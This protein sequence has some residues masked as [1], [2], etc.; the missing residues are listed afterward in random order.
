M[1]ATFSYK[2]TIRDEKAKEMLDNGKVVW[3]DWYNGAGNGSKWIVWYKGKFY[4]IVHDGTGN[5]FF[6]KH[7]AYEISEE[8]AKDIL[9]KHKKA[10]M[11]AKQ[12]FGWEE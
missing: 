3:Y 9:R 10:W 2:E 8:K 7:G 1:G 6:K 4:K 5:E 12:I 11:R